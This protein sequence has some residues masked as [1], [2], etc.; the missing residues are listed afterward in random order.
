MSLPVPFVTY[1]QN[2][3]WTAITTPAFPSPIVTSAYHHTVDTKFYYLDPSVAIHRSRW[4]VVFPPLQGS[5]REAVPY[6]RFLYHPYSG[7]T[8]IAAYTAEELEQL[9]TGGWTIEDSYVEQ[10]ALWRLRYNWMLNSPEDRLPEE[11]A[12]AAKKRHLDAYVAH[13][14]V[15]YSD[16]GLP[17]SALM[18]SFDG[19]VLIV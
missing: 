4:P 10:Y 19:F 16:G 15:M 9:T 7:A 8:L 13:F 5:I 1:T 14:N 6:K 18:N 3:T 12:S 11:S 2:S 17:L